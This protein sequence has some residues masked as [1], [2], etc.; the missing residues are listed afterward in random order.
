MNVLK[1]KQYIARYI[2]YSDI[3]NITLM[4]VFNL[5]IINAF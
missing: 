1:I 3:L 4:Y 2:L 5:K